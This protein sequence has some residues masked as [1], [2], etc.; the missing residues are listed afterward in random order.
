MRGDEDKKLSKFSADF[1]SAFLCR[2]KINKNAWRMPE[3]DKR[4]FHKELKNLI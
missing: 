1:S 2:Q 3:A 4:I